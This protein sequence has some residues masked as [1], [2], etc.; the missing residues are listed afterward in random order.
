MLLFVVSAGVCQN[1]C[2]VHH[3]R[4]LLCGST[5]STGKSARSRGKIQM[6]NGKQPRAQSTASGDAE[7]TIEAGGG[8]VESG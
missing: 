2:L 5:N 6:A 8:V 7:L 4:S 1:A 3:G